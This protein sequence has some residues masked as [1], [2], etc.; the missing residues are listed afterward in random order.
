MKV[1]NSEFICT[2]AGLGALFGTWE[3]IRQHKQSG[4]DSTP[5]GFETE[6]YIFDKFVNCV[7]LYQ[8]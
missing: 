8:S 3:R 1:A 7:K 5:L 4:A 6:S 2:P